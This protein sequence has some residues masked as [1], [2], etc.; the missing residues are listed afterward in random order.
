MLQNLAIWAGV[1]SGNVPLLQLRNQDS[2][3]YVGFLALAKDHLLFP[4]LHMPWRTEPAMFNPM[5][6]VFGRVGSWLN[7]RPEVSFQISQVIMLAIAGIVLVW[8]LDLFLST[9]AQR[10]AAIVA[11]LCALPV[12][13]FALALV[14]FFAPNLAYLFWVG[15]IDLSYS[16][17]DG[18]LRAGL[19]NS[20][21]L[22]FGT[23]ALLVSFSFAAARLETGHKGFSYA[24]AAAVFLSSLVHPFEVFV[25]VPSVVATFLWIERDA[26]RELI[27]TILAAG[28]GLAPHVALMLLHPWLADLS[29]SF[30]TVADFPHLVLR[31][32]LG[33][34]AI[35]YMFLIRSWPSKKLD[36]LLTVS[37][38]SITLISILPGAPFPPHLLD[39]Y[40]LLSG[41]LLVRLAMT[42]QKLRENHRLHPQVAKAA[43]A[44]VLTIAVFC[45]VPLIT[46]L[47]RD[48]GKLSPELLLSSVASKDEAALLAEFRNRAK[49]EDLVLAPEPVAMLLITAPMHA[50]S[51]HQH[52]SMDY[53]RQQSEAEAFF[54]HK[55]PRDGAR[56]LLRRNGIAWVVV[57]QDSPALDYFAGMDAE[58]MAGKFRVFHPAENRM[59]DYPGLAT[60]RPD[61]SPGLLHR[62]AERVAAH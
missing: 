18:L 27:P 34:L 13:V 4:N 48:G 25:I 3:Q 20:P 5:F 62:L 39:G 49:L 7:L 51:T 19:S 17:A 11:A 10:A 44:V 14:R 59:L 42:N 28:A 43:F 58:F 38:I 47:L 29:Q 21:V 23:S 8:F 60:I 53:F 32:G 40:S 56:E 16:T 45:Y 46:Q 33:F 35:P 31:Y 12:P 2:C 9:R 61:R 41:A 50:F 22:T 55:L 54:N 52:L 30:D 37:W 36:K 24:L 1:F 26:V 57:P 15:I 6:L